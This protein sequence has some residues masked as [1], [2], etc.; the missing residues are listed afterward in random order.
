MNEM[1]PD[2]QINPIPDRAAFSR[3]LEG[4]AGRAD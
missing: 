1:P 2:P 3:P 4:V